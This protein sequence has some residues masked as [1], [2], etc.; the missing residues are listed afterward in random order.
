M[1]LRTKAICYI[2]VQRACCTQIWLKL[3]CLAQ[4]D[5]KHG[6][7]KAFICTFCYFENGSSTAIAIACMKKDFAKMKMVAVPKVNGDDEEIKA[8]MHFRSAIAII[9][10][11]YNS[12]NTIKSQDIEEMEKNGAFDG[13]KG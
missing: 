4:R 13:L 5:A 10:K 9:L 6:E 2:L 11:I 8:P 7:I 1:T 3:P 12:P